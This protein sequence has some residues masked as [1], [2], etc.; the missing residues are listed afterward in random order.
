MRTDPTQ[1]LEAVFGEHAPGLTIEETARRSQRKFVRG[2]DHIALYELDVNPDATGHIMTAWEAYHAFG[3]DILVEAMEYG[4]AV[5]LS[6]RRAIESSLRNRREELGLSSRRVARSAGV[7]E[8]VVAHAEEDSRSL[9]IQALERV[10]FVLG[11]D[12]RRLAYHATS[13][14]DARLAARLKTLVAEPGAN[15][16]SLSERSVVRLAEAASIVRI[17]SEL[18]EALFGESLYA[19]FEPYGDYGHR[20]NPAYRIGYDLAERTRDILGLEVRPIESVRRLAE[21]ILGI[22]VIQAS[23]QEHISGATVA[24]TD[25]RGKEHRGIVLNVEGPNRNVWARRITLAHEIGHLLYDPDDRLERV[26]VDSYEGSN[27]NPEYSEDYVEQRANAFAVAFLA[28]LDAVR[29]REPM[30]A[31]GRPISGESI[32]RVMRHFGMSLTSARFHLA[33]AHYR[34][35]DTPSNRDIPDTRPDDVW[36]AAEDF[37]VDYFRPEETPIQRRGRF[38]GLVAT[39]YDSGL[40]SDHTAAA[41]LH[42]EVL[43]FLDNREEIMD[44]YPF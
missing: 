38:A 39:A 24:A 18:R 8:E 32:S 2:A 27:R 12:E 40:I 25:G 35:Y 14:A 33:N 17:Q 21:D 19:R 6:E 43:E 28:P 23:L 15:D 42:C 11:L 44:M 34:Q 41:Y 7:S 36:R 26:R 31:P 29:D 9:P 4:S 13:G 37:A 5:I 16:V 30:P 20:E 3:L 10:A 1:Y 22:P